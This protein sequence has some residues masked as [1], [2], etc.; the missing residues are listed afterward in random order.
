MARREISAGAGGEVSGHRNAYETRCAAQLGEAFAYEPIKLSYTLACT[1]LP[2]FVDEANKRIVEAKGLFDAA[3]RRKI[4]AVK[5]QNPDYTI[6]IWFQNP[7]RKISK[8][9]ATSYADWC[10]RHGIAWKQ[11]PKR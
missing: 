8:S 6:E 9:S 11:G 2:D 4:L 5:S 7:N 10:D 1:Y 3:D